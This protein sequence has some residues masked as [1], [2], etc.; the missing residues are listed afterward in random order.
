MEDK[1]AGSPISAF[2]NKNFSQIAMIEK[3]SLAIFALGQILY[4][5][6]QTNFNFIL[7]IGSV[8][9]AV[10]YFLFSFKTIEI[11]SVKDSS[12][13]GSIAIASFAYKLS[14]WGL[15]I[16]SVAFIFFVTE[17]KSINQLL[18]VGGGTSLF[19]LFFSIKVHG[20]LKTKMFDVFYYLRM[21]AFILLLAVFL[22]MRTDLINMY[23]S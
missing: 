8:L 17:S 21:I 4:W 3:I 1:K 5:L 11:D 10:I 6:K 7:I 20:D 19:A 2:V 23:T 13:I 22:F 12:S 9:V 16:I 15:A 14:Y 18:I